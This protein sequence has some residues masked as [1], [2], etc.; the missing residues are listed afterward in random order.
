MPRMNAKTLK[1]T[2][3]VSFLASAACFAANPQM[4]TWK[5]D[6]AK[7]NGFSDPSELPVTYVVDAKG[8]IRAKLSP[9]DM[10]VTE[11]SLAAAVLPLLPR[12]TPMQTH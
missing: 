9:D 4:G 5:L 1:L 6:D 3:A 12:G 8:V 10:P 2:L 7:S 11:Q